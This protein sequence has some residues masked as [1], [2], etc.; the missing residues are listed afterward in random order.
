V[1][2]QPT[3]RTADRICRRSRY[4]GDGG[5]VSARVVPTQITIRTRGVSADDEEITA[6]AEVV[7]ADSCRDEHRIP[8]RHIELDTLRTAELDPGAA[9][10]NAQ[11][12]VR[13]AVV[14]AEGE[15]AVSP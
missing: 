13:S 9:T 8:R 15:D 11:H 2:V 12:F 14:V 7:V 1:K 10:C 4:S 5:I 3:L 6:G